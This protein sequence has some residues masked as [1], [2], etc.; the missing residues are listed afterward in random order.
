MKR[1]TCVLTRFD[2]RD[3][4]YVEVAPEVKP[5]SEDKW[6]EFVLCK[7]GYGIKNFMFG[8]KTEDCPEHE[9]EDIIEAEVDDHI[10]MFIEEMAKWDGADYCDS[11]DCAGRT[12]EAIEMHNNHVDK[13]QDL[14]DTL[15]KQYPDVEKT[16]VNDAFC[17]AFNSVIGSAIHLCCEANGFEMDPVWM[18]T[19]DWHVVKD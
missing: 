9:W 12:Y 8:L 19:E 17:K 2:V 7:E 15:L 6:I 10:E 4:F 1:T 18:T 3:G 5:Q 16:P 14:G 11:H 13:L